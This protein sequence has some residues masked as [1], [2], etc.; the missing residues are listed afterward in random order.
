METRLGIIGILVNRKKSQIVSSL[1]KILSDHSE[2]II[3]RMGVNLRESELG[4]ISLIVEGDTDRIGSLAGKLGNLEGV[5]IK[6]MLLSFRDG[7]RSDKHDQ[8]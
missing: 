4:I 1:N 7:K 8:R 5:R 6:T 2:I 3:G